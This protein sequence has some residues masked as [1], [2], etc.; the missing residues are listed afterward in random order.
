MA[1]QKRI[2][3]SIIIA[4]SIVAARPAAAQIP[5]LD[6]VQ[7]LRAALDIAH[8]GGFV[9]GSSVSVP[10]S[11]RTLVTQNPQV[12]MLLLDIRNGRAGAPLLTALREAGIDPAA[13]EATSALLLDAEET[14][15]ALDEIG[16]S[17]QAR[18]CGC[19]ADEVAAIGNVVRDAAPPQLIERTHVFAGTLTPIVGAATPTSER[20]AIRRVS[21]SGLYSV[22]I[23]N[24]SQPI[25]LLWDVRRNAFTGASLVGDRYLDVSLTYGRVG[26]GQTL[27][28]EYWPTARD[29]STGWKRVRAPDSQLEEMFEGRFDTDATEEANRIRFLP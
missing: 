25:L 14:A 17:P 11:L 6:G 13:L 27:R 3:A 29:M 26:Y 9:L 24:T 15:I 16:E 10:D 23:G 5:A 8:E 7:P 4:F 20:I 19:P 21:D 2:G 22:R 28:I 12:R 1:V 18:M